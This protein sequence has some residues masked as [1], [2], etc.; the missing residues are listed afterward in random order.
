MDSIGEERE[1][2]E[3]DIERLNLALQVE[4]ST[5]ELNDEEEEELDDIFTNEDSIDPDDYESVNTIP[6]Q[7][8]EPTHV[9]TSEI[10]QMSGMSEISHLPINAET[11][12]ALNRTYQELILESLKKIELALDENREKQKVL[13]EGLETK[14]KGAPKTTDKSTTNKKK[15]SAMFCKPYFKDKDQKVAP[16]NSDVEMKKDD[17]GTQTRCFSTPGLE[18]RPEM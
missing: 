16:Y 7:D 1:Q 3:D 9:E 2:I 14:S 18:H 8:S 10:D 4:G 5:V 11:C 15:S 6:S 13:E 12:L 17:S